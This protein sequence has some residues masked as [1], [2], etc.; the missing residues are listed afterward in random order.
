MLIVPYVS[1]LV[2][3]HPAERL[4]YRD[5]ARA[6]PADFERVTGKQEV[7]NESCV[8]LC[9]TKLAIYSGRKE[10]ALILVIPFSAEIQRIR[11]TIETVAEER[12]GL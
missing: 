8:L 7:I 11:E 10:V 12:I 5:A 4:A 1:G 3:V 9:R 2:G 6:R